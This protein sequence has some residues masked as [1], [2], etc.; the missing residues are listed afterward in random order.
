MD[1]AEAF[2]LALAQEI[3]A[4]CKDVWANLSRISA[5]PHT[6]LSMSKAEEILRVLP[7][8]PQMFSAQDLITLQNEAERVYQEL[9]DEIIFPPRCRQRPRRTRT[10]SRSREQSAP[11]ESTASVGA[12]AASNPPPTNAAPPPSHR[13]QRHQ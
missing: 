13:R 11:P 7:D 10:V 6:P 1:P 2:H 9:W 12:A 8:F 3:V 4:L 5:S